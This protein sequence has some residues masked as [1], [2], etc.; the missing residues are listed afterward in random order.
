MITFFVVVV[1]VVMEKPNTLLVSKREVK[2]RG[3]WGAPDVGHYC[4]AGMGSSQG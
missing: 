2:R 3:T 4:P 1:V